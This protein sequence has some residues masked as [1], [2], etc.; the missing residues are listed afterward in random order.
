MATLCQTHT[1]DLTTPVAITDTTAVSHLH[2][3]PNIE[4]NAIVSMESA[5][6]HRTRCC[7]YPRAHVS[8]TAESMMANCRT[9]WTFRKVSSSPSYPL[10]STTW[11]TACSAMPYKDNI[12]LTRLTRAYR[13]IP[14][15]P[16][17]TLSNLSPAS[18]P[19]ACMATSA[20]KTFN[21]VGRDIFR[22]PVLESSKG[23]SF[24]S[25]SSHCTGLWCW[26]SRYRFHRLRTSSPLSEP[27]ASFN[28][29][30]PFLL[31]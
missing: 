18:L 27:P 11:S 3:L 28:S 14:S 13:H 30:T 1:C 7:S 17:A 19:A 4:C 5:T 21:N 20:L 16:L 15:K 8:P 12:S 6:S 23:N 22:F 29:R 10:A 2:S 26:P 31:S 25:S 9:E 24:G